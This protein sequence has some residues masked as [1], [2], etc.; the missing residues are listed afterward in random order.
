MQISNHDKNEQNSFLNIKSLLY[1]SLIHYH[2][3][4]WHLQQNITWIFC[5]GFLGYT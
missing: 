4:I 1:C 5:K 3:W 2:S